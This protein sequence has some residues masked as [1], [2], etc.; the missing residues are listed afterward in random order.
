MKI[1]NWV[2]CFPVLVIFSPRFSIVKYQGPT[3]PR[4]DFLGSVYIK[5]QHQRG[6]NS[7]WHSLKTMESLEN[8][9]QLH[10]GVTPLFSM[11]TES[12]ASSQKYR[13]VGAN[14]WCKRALRVRSHIAI[15]IVGFTPVNH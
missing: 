6:D 11:R 8:G 15:S 9:L 14:A 13:S 5:R 3:L 12:L 7:V 2:D 1:L 10:S 4:P